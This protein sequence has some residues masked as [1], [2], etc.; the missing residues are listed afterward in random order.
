MSGCARAASGHAAAPPSSVMNWRR[1]MPDMGVSHP[2]RW[3]S[4]TLNLAR[5]NP[6]VLW[7]ILNRSEPAGTPLVHVWNGVGD[8]VVEQLAGSR[9]VALHKLGG[10]AGPTQAYRQ[11]FLNLSGASSV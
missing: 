4:R 5:G 7:A 10:R 6:Q 9:T 11:K 3:V 1:F 8:D 2:V